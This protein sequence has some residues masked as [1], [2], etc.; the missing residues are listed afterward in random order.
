MIYVLI[1]APGAG[2]GT[3]AD[4]LVQSGGFAK[5]STGDALRNQIKLGTDVGKEASS[6]MSEGKLVPDDILLEILR[7]ELADKSDEKVILDGYPRNL[8]QAKTLMDLDGISIKGAVHIDVPNDDLIKRLTGRQV[9]SQCGSSYH[10]DFSPPKKQG[11]C[12]KCSGEIV[13]R[14]DDAADKVAVRLQ[15]YE[16][17]TK[18]VLD[19]FRD[20]GL[21]IRVDG[22]GSGEAVQERLVRALNSL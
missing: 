11:V 8:E 3:Q 16:E 19:Y 21:Y 2:K 5:L 9:C 18:P 7:A 15:V 22:T 20:L 4:L 10:V 13:Q 12:D 6:Y 1:G 14:P 17:N